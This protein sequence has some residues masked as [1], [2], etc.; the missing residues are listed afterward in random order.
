MVHL[1]DTNLFGRIAIS[2]P[3]GRRPLVPPEL[4]SEQNGGQQ[5]GQYRIFY[6]NLHKKEPDKNGIRKGCRRNEA[7]NLINP[8]LQN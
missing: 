1:E 7:I 5:I 8:Y 2:F 6:L 3:S 4:K